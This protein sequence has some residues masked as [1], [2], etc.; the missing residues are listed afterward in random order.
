MLSFFCEY[1]QFLTSSTHP[2]LFC[3]L[4]FL[5]PLLLSALLLPETFGKEKYNT[6]VPSL[7]QSLSKAPSFL[8]ETLAPLEAQLAFLLFR[9]SSRDCIQNAI[10]RGPSAISYLSLGCFVLSHL[11]ERALTSRALFS[12]IRCDTCR[13]WW[14]LFS[15]RE[16]R[17]NQCLAASPGLPQSI[18]IKENLSN[19]DWFLL[20]PLGAFFPWCK[21]THCLEDRSADFHFWDKGLDWIC[22]SVLQLTCSQD[23]I[24]TLPQLWFLY[25]LAAAFT[26]RLNFIETELKMHRMRK[27]PLL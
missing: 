27:M 20:V 18:Y 16:E 13:C 26:G 22:S 2:D 3:F 24:V 23:I 14:I 4:C 15:N 21:V 10:Q 12:P 6:S 25:G 17:W 19:E 9:N 7:V 1:F 8:L 11:I 5:L